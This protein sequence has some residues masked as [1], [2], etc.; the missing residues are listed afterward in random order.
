MPNRTFAF[1]ITTILYYKRNY[2]I[3]MLAYFKINFFSPTF[4]KWTQILAIGVPAPSNLVTTPMPNCACIT[5]SPT[6]TLVLLLTCRFLMEP[7]SARES[8]VRLRAVF[9]AGLPIFGGSTLK[10]YLC[11]G[12]SAVGLML[13]VSCRG[14]SDWKC[15]SISSEDATLEYSVT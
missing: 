13:S 8:G 5:L 3:F 4:W 1:K 7:A 10:W 14:F 12:L 6:F 9:V 11:C 15:W 2:T